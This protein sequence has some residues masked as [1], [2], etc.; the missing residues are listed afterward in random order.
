MVLI[1][2]FVRVDGVDGFATNFAKRLW[3]D[4]YFDHQTRK[5]AKKP[6]SS[7]SGRS[8]VEF[9]LEPIYKIF[10]QVLGEDPKD[11]EVR[12]RGRGVDCAGRWVVA[13]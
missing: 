3:G 9:V 4:L 5:F 2:S 1:V 12:A 8:F 6:T 13:G 10:A 7:K 11:L